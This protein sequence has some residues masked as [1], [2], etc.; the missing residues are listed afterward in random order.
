MDRF[1]AIATHWLN[2]GVPLARIRQSVVLAAKWGKSIENTIR[3]SYFVCRISYVVF[4]I[5]YFVFRASYV[6]IRISQ[7]TFS[8]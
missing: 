3:N 5:S 7:L 6:A 8:C 1:W 2:S 4:R